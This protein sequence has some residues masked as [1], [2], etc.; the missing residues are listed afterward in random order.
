M[1]FTM[2]YGFPSMQALCSVHQI[3]SGIMHSVWPVAKLCTPF[4]QRAILD[5]GEYTSLPRFR[6]QV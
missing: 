5:T 2:F 1:C 3:T 4:V 6:R